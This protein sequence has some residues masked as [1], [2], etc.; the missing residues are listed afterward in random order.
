MSQ[1]SNRS[2]QFAKTQ[3]DDIPT[4]LIYTQSQSSPTSQFDT[5]NLN[6][7]LVDEQ[8]QVEDDDD[9]HSISTPT[10]SQAEWIDRSILGDTNIVAQEEVRYQLF[11]SESRLER[12]EEESFS[13][14]STIVQPDVDKYLEDDVDC[15]KSQASNQSQ[16][17][18]SSIQKHDDCYSQSKYFKKY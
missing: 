1:E 13:Q 6:D 11:V 4:Q 7:T 3:T 18:A 15:Y 10:T 16:S 14:L 12:I 9:Y 5:L 8:D 17:Q 2:S